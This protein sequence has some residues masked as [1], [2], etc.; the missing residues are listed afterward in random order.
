MAYTTI[1]DPSVY[2]Q[3]ALYTSNDTN[4]TITNDGN[5]DLQPDFLWGKSRS[6]AEDH[7][8]VNTLI[9]VNKYQVS[10]TNAAEASDTD[11]V[12]GVTSDGFSIGTDHRWNRESDSNMVV[13]QWKGTGGT[14]TAFASEAD[15]ANNEYD[16]HVNQAAGF[17]INA[18]VG[19]GANST[20][21][22]G[23]GAA[24]DFVVT[25]QRSQGSRGWTTWTNALAGN[26]ALD[27]NETNGVYTSAT[28]WNSTVPSSSAIS[29]GTRVGT[30]EDGRNF[31]MYC[32]KSIQGYSKIGSYIG[33][34]ST[35][36][37]FIY[38]GFKPGWLM[39]KGISA[40][41]REWFLFDGKRD[42]INP[43]AKYVKAESSDAEAS[44][45]F[46]DFL[47]N[48]FKVRSDGASYNTSGQTFIYYAIAEHPF[49]SSEG[50]PVTAK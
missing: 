42:P 30:N 36:G 11:R 28:S 16:L 26:Q 20:V 37:P 22:H 38:T 27:L 8:L 33:N 29:L 6:F 41:S 46:G 45:A 48:G 1:D 17:S 43:F 23:L 24:P 13:W 21:P 34:G 44:S 2:F 18:Y 4:R 32:F 50:V 47:S 35:N 19:T 14:R 9:G 10:N 15:N 3:I 25:K 49:V 40:N 12:T 31:I 39:V 7:N 5:S